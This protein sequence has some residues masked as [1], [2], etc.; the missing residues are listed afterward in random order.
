[1]A[2]DDYRKHLASV[3]I[4]AG[5][6]GRQL[7]EIAK[8]ADELWVEPGTEFVRQ[9]EIGQELFILLDG[10]AVVSR[11][12]NPIATLG[13]SDF[14]GEL[15]V[16][17]PGRRRNASVTAESRVELL[18][19]TRAGLDQLLDD[20]PGL[21]KALLRVVVARLSETDFSHRA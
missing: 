11:D 17:L 6:N 20:I 18:V 4:F 15:S 10:T 8:V 14:A 1:V 19:V 7:D 5:L 3:P 2:R 16:L 21:A 13:R 9:G 12:G